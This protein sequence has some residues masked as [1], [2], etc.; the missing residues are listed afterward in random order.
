MRTQGADSHFLSATGGV[1]EGEESAGRWLGP[2][3]RE[4]LWSSSLLPWK[5]ERRS[6]KPSSPIVSCV[7]G[8]RIK[9]KTK[10]GQYSSLT[11]GFWWNLDTRY[12]MIKVHPTKEVQDVHTRTIKDGRRIMLPGGHY[13]CQRKVNIFCFVKWICKDVNA[14]WCYCT[15]TK[16]LGEQRCWWFHNISDFLKYN[17]QNTENNCTCLCFRTHF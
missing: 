2:S 6:K 17:N 11:T 8:F 1:E 10:Y 15:Q 5:R 16:D 14:F 3:R 4:H 9:T 12:A 13:W 7:A